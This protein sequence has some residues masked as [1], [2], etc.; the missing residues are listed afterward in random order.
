MAAVN[1]KT[2]DRLPVGFKAT[3]DMLE[4]LKVHF[5]ADTERDLINALP[6]DTY[7]AF[8]NINES[9]YPEYAGGPQ[10][11]VYPEAYADG[12]WDSI[13]GYKRHYVDA[14]KGRN[15]EVLNRPLAGV[16]NAEEMADHE[17]PEADWFNYDCIDEQCRKANDH[18]VI[19][20]IGGLGHFSN[21]I[22]FERF[23]TDL[24][25][26][27]GIIEYGFTRIMD[28][29]VDFAERILSAADGKIDIVVIEDDFGTQRGPLISLEMY[30]KF[31]K[32]QHK[33]FFDVV[34]R[35]GAK[36]VQHSCGAVFDFI[37]DF[38]EIG[39]DI[40]DPIQVTADGMDPDRLEKEFGRDI[41]FHGGLSTQD[42][43]VNGT[44]HEVKKEIDRLVE[45]FSG[46]G[47][48]ILA[49]DHYMN[50]DAPIEN[51]LA[52]FEHLA[53]YR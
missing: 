53:K 21:L 6:V 29:N 46:D 45:S 36:M 3:D 10:K 2:P 15:D 48:Y 12:T 1:H 47:G 11:V 9:I 31:Y 17:W 42:T 43:L 35:H 7:G 13:Y 51:I 49:P 40:L 33:R 5:G 18:A 39:A 44:P 30:R 22:G 8:N 16:E 23:L 26:N 50:I 20:K 52:V 19:F 28:F 41:C 4:A 24:Y 32:P 14:A 25:L 38:I 27:P 34:H 37:A